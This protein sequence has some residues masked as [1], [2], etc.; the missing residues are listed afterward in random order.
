M[1]ISTNQFYQTG[2]NSILDQQNQLSITQ[3]KISTG[4]KVT[5]PSDDPIATISIINLEQEIAITERYN[6]NADLAESYLSVE[7]SSLQ[8]V[9]DVLQRGLRDRALGDRVGIPVEGG[10]VPQ[11]DAVGRD[12]A[13]AGEDPLRIV[14]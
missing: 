3:G 9:I 6:K 7:E 10:Q 2:L 1:R 12:R 8:K 5:K 11:P 13:Q 14:G 4:L